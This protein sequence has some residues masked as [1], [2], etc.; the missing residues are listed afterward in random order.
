MAIVTPGYF[1][2]MGIPLLKGRDFTRRD[3]VDAPRVLI[4]NQAFAQKYF[5]GEDVL[6]K[7][8]EPGATNGD[9][10][11][12]LREIIGVVGNAKQFALSAEP[13]P[14][15]YFPY[16]QLSWG[17]GTFVLRT[18]VPPLEL[19]PAARAVLTKMDRQAAIFQVLTGEERAALAVAP[20][21]F[22]TTLVG[23]FAVI[24]VALTLSGLYGVL[25]YAVA[26]RRREIG[27]RIALGAGTA[28]VVAL[29]FRGAMQLVGAGLVLGLAG[30]AGCLR[31]LES[32]VFGVQPGDPAILG[33]ACALMAITSVAAAY[34]PAKRAASVDATEA[35]RSE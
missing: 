10:G 1:S 15:Y 24:A 16:E 23:G 19:E 12:R 7:R 9:E 27:V 25:S 11:T 28:E 2:A 5:P 18:A 3:G 31:L 22:I 29:V 17:T 21:R 8:I 4:V 32:V 34:V 33:S 30:I 20:M 13:D 14:I 26:R 6:G 35:L